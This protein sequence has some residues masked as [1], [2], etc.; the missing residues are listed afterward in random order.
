MKMVPKHQWNI[1]LLLF[2]ALPTNKVSVFTAIIN[3][4]GASDLPDC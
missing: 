1:L 3:Y 4:Y 2:S